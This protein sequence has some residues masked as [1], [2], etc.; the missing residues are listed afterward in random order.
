MLPDLT[1]MDTLRDLLRSAP[2]IGVD[3]RAAAT[4]RNA[5]LTKPPGALGRLE[6]LSAWAAAWRNI[7]EGSPKTAI[8]GV[9]VRGSASSFSTSTAR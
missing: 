5:Q 3:A 7:W 1:N 2:G 8:R 9:T 4:E 6:N